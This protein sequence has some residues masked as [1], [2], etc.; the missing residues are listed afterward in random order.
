MRRRRSAAEFSLGRLA[1]Y[2]LGAGTLALLLA[3][4]LIMVW[5][6]SPEI[7]LAIA[8][9]GLV[10]AIAAM[11]FVSTRMTRRAIAEIEAEEEQA[12]TRS[13]KIETK[14]EGTRA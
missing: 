7:G 4:I 3:T 12:K 2:S 9:L 14:D 5:Q 11:G 1:F 6:P 10:G 13:P 8:L